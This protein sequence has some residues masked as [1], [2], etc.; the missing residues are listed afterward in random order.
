MVNS[1]VLGRFF[2]GK[3]LI[4]KL[5]PRVKVLL[6]ILM[7]ILTFIG[8]N[9]ISLLLIF[10]SVLICVVV[11]KVPYKL[12]FKSMKSIIFIIFFTSALNIFYGQGEPIF[13]L[14]FIKITKEGINN[15][16]FVAVRLLTLI[17][18]SSILTFTTSPTDLTDALERLLKPLKFIKVNVHDISMIM[19]IA[20]RFVPT[21]IE[22]ADKIMC[23][24]KSRGA[25]FEAGKLNERIKALTPIL[26]PLFVSSFRRAYELA[27]AMECRCYN[28]GYGRTRM[29]ALKLGAADFFSIIYVLTITC[30][31]IYTNL[32]L[33]AVIK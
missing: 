29:R 6:D 25:D 12:Y 5:D 28:G 30:V 22:E 3:S 19:T 27:I 32:I 2:P 23:A 31:I 1:I 9:Y 13:Q 14:W 15:S 18:L 26:I 7:I 24:Q 17:I 10:I 20:L 21:L 16:I 8:Q 4:H 33:P 11:S